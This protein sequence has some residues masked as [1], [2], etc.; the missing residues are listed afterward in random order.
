MRTT[1]K[2][3]EKLVAILAEETG[4]NYHCEGCA[5]GLYNVQEH[6]PNHTVGS[7]IITGTASECYYAIH[8]IRNHLRIEQDRRHND[9]TEILVYVQ[10]GVVHDVYTK[11]GATYRVIDE[12][13]VRR[14]FYEDMDTG[15]MRRKAIMEETRNCPTDI[16]LQDFSL[17]AIANHFYP[18]AE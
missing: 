7:P 16:G 2:M 5:P 8:A 13:E 18:E 15:K 6:Y 11:E 14:H 12:D 9:P 4:I 10:G 17:E 3:L 1:Y